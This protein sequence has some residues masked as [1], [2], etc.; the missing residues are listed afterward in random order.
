MALFCPRCVEVV[1][2]YPSHRDR[3]DRCRSG[4][5][6]VLF[7]IVGFVWRI[8]YPLHFW[9]QH[10]SIFDY[11]IAGCDLY[12]VADKDGLSGDLSAG[13]V[14]SWSP[15]RD[16]GSLHPNFT[17]LHPFT[18]SNRM[19]EKHDFSFSNCQNIH[20]LRIYPS[21]INK[22]LISF[23]NGKPTSSVWRVSKVFSK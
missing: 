3:V 14:V 19:R 15:I 1:F 8:K 9:R 21:E 22:H 23:R 5:Q 13:I 7:Y 20:P 18:G 2:L 6:C 11:C 4:D 12:F 17:V 10:K 16:V